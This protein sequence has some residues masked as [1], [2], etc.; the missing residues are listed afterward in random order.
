MDP[1]TAATSGND[2]FDI[3]QA[4]EKIGE[5]TCEALYWFDSDSV[6]MSLDPDEYSAEFSGRL[7]EAAENRVAAAGFDVSREDVWN[8]INVTIAET[9]E[10][11][12]GAAPREHEFS[13][14][15]P[16]P[17]IFRYRAPRARRTRGRPIR[18]RGSRR[19]TVS[20]GGGSSGDDPDPEPPA[21]SRANRPS[22][23][24]AVLL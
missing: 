11:R 3:D 9:D 8:E 1:T 24:Q 10:A 21:R 19:T 16:A 7:R 2:N 12:I 14:V 15:P 6:P 17:H 22:F 20:T 23:R 18:R 4:A 5:V 13:L